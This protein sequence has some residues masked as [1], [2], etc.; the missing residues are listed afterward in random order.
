[1]A[2][3]A[4]RA[5]VFRTVL[6]LVVCALTSGCAREAPTSESTFREPD[7][8]R[9][10]QVIRSRAHDRRQKAAVLFAL[11]AYAT[12]PE[13]LVTA[14]S[15]AEK[16]VE[17]R[18]LLLVVPRGT[19]DANSQFFWNASLGCCV[20]TPSPPDDLGYLRAV[21]RDVRK[22]YV[23]DPE[24][25]YALGVSN[26]GFMAH[27]WACAAGGDLRGIVAV[28]GVGPGIGDA[29]CEPSVPV[30]VLQIHGDADDVIAYDGGVG[31]R[32][33]Y[34]SA[35]ATVQR[36]RDLNHCGAKPVEDSDWSAL[37]GSTSWARCQ[38]PSAEVAFWTFKGGG[39]HLRSLRFAVGEL[40]DFLEQ[41]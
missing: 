36:W 4:V 9:D 39:H 3:M 8:Q 12:A 27:R 21:L 34:P 23:V 11:H 26:G 20:N 33:P 32:G 13:T 1:M 30:R 16:A 22:R 38:G 15:L 25:V 28:S 10:Y 2:A 29:P 6:G 37:H 35:P 41:R 24:R 19:K 7:T 18:G 31:T 5:R 17:G 40:L 14:W